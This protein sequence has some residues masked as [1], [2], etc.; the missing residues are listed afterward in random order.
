M[1]K[2]Q[3]K[4]FQDTELKIHHAFVELLSVKNINN[5]TVNE[6][7]R[8]AQIS[9]PSFY[10]HYDDIN[11]LI[12]QMEQAKS[13]QIQKMLISDEPLTIES[14]QEYFEFLKNNK[15]FYI[16]YLGTANNGTTAKHLMK[17]FIHK[18]KST[19]PD[20]LQYQMIFLMAGIK[21]VAYN[22]LLDGCK[23]SSRVLAEMIHAQYQQL[24]V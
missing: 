21:S 15:T 17:T 20:H 11:D 1:N 4:R 6:L 24:L 9:R 2:S 23:T 12:I 7:C 10:F 19:T 18:T 14:F 5:I 8:T 13:T 22:W 3:N 16:A